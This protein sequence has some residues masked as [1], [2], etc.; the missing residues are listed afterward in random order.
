MS[1][2]KPATCRPRPPAAGLLLN[3]LS[4]FHGCDIV[5]DSMDVPEAA[6][7]SCRNVDP[8]AMV[9]SSLWTHLLGTC[10]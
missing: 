8:G 7:D 6:L 4:V 5:F 10:G 1:L 3:N 2:C 9:G